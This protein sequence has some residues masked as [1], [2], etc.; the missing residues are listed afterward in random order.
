MTGNLVD[1][2]RGYYFEDFEVDQTFVTGSITVTEDAII[3]FAFEWDPQPFHID[4]LAAEKGVFGKLVA[5]GLQTMLLTSR[6]VYDFGVLSGTALAGLGFDDVRF[7]KPL[8]P[9]DTIH[10][11]LKILEMEPSSKPERGRVNVLMRTINQNDEL[12]YH[13][14]LIVFIARRS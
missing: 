10:V 2:A 9:G 7:V 3:R 1:L 12:I 11:E 6:L 5:S 4:R 14:T 8:F 13:T